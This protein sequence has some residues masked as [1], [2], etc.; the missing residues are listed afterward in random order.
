LE[1][2]F[3][4]TSHQKPG[5]QGRNRV[6]GTGILAGVAGS[7]V[8]ISPAARRNRFQSEPGRSA[9]SPEAAY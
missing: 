2:G 9:A 1:T 7:F 6:S 4:F 5:F 3:L 8:T